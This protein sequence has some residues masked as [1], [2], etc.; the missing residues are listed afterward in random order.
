MLW[1]LW[2]KNRPWTWRWNHKLMSRWR[3][4]FQWHFDDSNCYYLFL[5]GG[6]L[7][8]NLQHVVFWSHSN[9]RYIILSQN[10]ATPKTLSKMV[11]YKKCIILRVFGEILNFWDTVVTGCGGTHHRNTVTHNNCWELPT[12]CHARFAISASADPKYISH[13]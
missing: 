5:R 12:W 6:V 9:V 11:S 8:S 2:Y 3:F 4:L 7:L 13:R 1:F 10:S